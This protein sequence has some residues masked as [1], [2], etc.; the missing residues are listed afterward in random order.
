LRI[1]HLASVEHC[2]SVPPQ[3]ICREAKA[4]WD[5]K[6]VAAAHRTGEVGITQPSVI[7]AVSSPH[8]REAIEACH[9]LIDELKIRVPVWKRER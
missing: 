6:K 8:R 2:P 4:R 5:L 3:E 7:L 1:I 9:F